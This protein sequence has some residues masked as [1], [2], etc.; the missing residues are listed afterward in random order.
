MLQNGGRPLAT[1]LC[2]RRVTLH[3]DRQV[4]RLVWVVRSHHRGNTGQRPAPGT[5]D[6]LDL[7]VNLGQHLCLAPAAQV[8]FALPEEVQV[9][10][11]VPV[12]H[13][14]LFVA[15][16]LGHQLL[17]GVLAHQF[18]QLVAAG[19]LIPDGGAAHLGVIHQRCQQRKAGASNPRRRL[20]VKTAAED[21]E[22]LQRTLLGRVQQLPRMVE[23]RMQVLVAFRYVA[24]AVAIY[25]DAVAPQ[26]SRVTAEASGG[27]AN[28]GVYNANAA[29]P[30]MTHM[31]IL[32]SGHRCNIGVYNDGAAPAMTYVS[33]TVAGGSISYGIYNCDGAA[34]VMS[35]VSATVAGGD[36]NFGVYND[37]DTWPTMTGVTARALGG[38]DSID[39]YND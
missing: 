6:V 19:S 3:Q 29:A 7:E 2:R 16:A 14:H 39:V 25:N 27:L 20:A 21:C 26:L 11:A 34:P 8:G 10:V 32:A 38:I 37:Q 33:A 35:Q 30:V 28:Y 17:S 31:R 18:L 13:G 15:G 9:V 22:L 23:D 36:R 4:A 12:E 5:T 24:F 1:L